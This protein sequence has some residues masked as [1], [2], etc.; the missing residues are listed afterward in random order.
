MEIGHC[1]GVPQL[2][3]THCAGVIPRS[4]D[5]KDHAVTIDWSS[6]TTGEVTQVCEKRNGSVRVR[7]RFEDEDK[8]EDLDLQTALPL[9]TDT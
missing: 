9:V 7:V 2:L 4:V 3:G 6:G 8:E 1:A 5:V